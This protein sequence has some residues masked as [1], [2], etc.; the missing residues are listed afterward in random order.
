MK[1]SYLV[2][3]NHKTQNMIS[4]N[5]KSLLSTNEDFKK[6][7]G[8][9]NLKN[10]ILNKSDDKKIYKEV[11]EMSDSDKC[12]KKNNKTNSIIFKSEI[13]TV[14]IIVKYT[15]NLYNLLVKLILLISKLI[16]N[17]YDKIP[18]N[19]LSNEI[20]YDENK[21]IKKIN[22]EINTKNN[23]TKIKKNNNSIK[24]INSYLIDLD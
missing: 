24:K 15:S 8:K 11:S 7:I 1:Y 16:I 22:K 14:E 9:K 12:E 6:F 17:T 13:N 4:E 18:S 20:N 3:E 2:K 23:K 19:Y 10:D 21:M 5:E